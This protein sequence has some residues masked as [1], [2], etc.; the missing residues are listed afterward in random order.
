[1]LCTNPSPARRARKAYAAYSMP[2]SVWKMI[3]G[4]GCRLT[5][6]W[7]SAARVSRA[8]LWRPRLHPTIRREAVHHHGEIAPRP[9]DLQV[10]DVAHPDLIRPGGQAPEVAVR[11]ARE[12]GMQPGDGAI[13]PRRASAQARLPHEALHTAPADPRPAARSARWTR[14][15]P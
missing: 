7:L 4:R 6:A 14:G 11:D 3:P 10:R 5:T 12:E 15:L 2:R 8:S 1:M 13:Q 9:A